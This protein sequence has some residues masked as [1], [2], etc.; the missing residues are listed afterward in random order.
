M[1]REKAVTIL[2]AAAAALLFGGVGLLFRRKDIFSALSHPLAEKYPRISKTFGT[3]MM[4]AA[5][6]WLW[7]VIAVV[8]AA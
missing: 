1:V 7:V 6:L 4:L 3:A 2:I 8:W 5:L